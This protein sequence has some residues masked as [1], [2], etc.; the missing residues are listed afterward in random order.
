MATYRRVAA[1]KSA[2]A[3]QAH[4]ADLGITMPFDEEVAKWPR[5]TPG[6]G[7]QRPRP[8]HR[9]QLCRPADGR[10][11]CRTGWHAQSIWCAGA[12]AAL[13]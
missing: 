13:G 8:H 12:G 10:L 9:Q 3:F 2:E 11:G 5:L 4:L 7:A 6:Q 1:L